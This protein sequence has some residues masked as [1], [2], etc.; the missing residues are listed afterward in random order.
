LSRFQEA[1]AH[2]DLAAKFRGSLVDD[3]MFAIDANEW[4]L[5]NLMEEYRERRLSSLSGKI[6]NK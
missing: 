4:G 3:K 2:P 6:P 1:V 5:E